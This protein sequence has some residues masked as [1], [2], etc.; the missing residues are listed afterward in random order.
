MSK[1]SN[2]HQIRVYA[3]WKGIETPFFIGNLYSERL[4]GKEIFSF[5]N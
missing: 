4:R 3:H 2:K 5:D 1:N